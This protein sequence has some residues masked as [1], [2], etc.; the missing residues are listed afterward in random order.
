MFYELG[1][2]YSR[3]ATCYLLNFLCCG[4]SYCFLQLPT[5]FYCF[6]LFPTVPTVSYCPSS[7]QQAPHPIGQSVSQSDSGSTAGSAPCPGEACSQL[8]LPLPTMRPSLILLLGLLSGP[9]S[10]QSPSDLPT[11]LPTAAP[12]VNYYSSYSYSSYGYAYSAPPS[13]NKTCENYGVTWHPKSLPFASFPTKITNGYFCEILQRSQVMQYRNGTAI[14]PFL[15][16]IPNKRNSSKSVAVT[17]KFNDFNGADPISGNVNL[18]V[19][20]SLT[21]KD[22]FTHWD[23]TT[24]CRDFDLNSTVACPT[25][26]VTYIG[27]SQ[28]ALWLPDFQLSNDAVPFD[29]GFPAKQNAVVNYNGLTT[30]ALTG[31]IT[32]GCNYVLTDFPFDTQYCEADFTSRT[33]YD[34]VLK[35]VLDDSARKFKTN[36]ADPS[37]A[38]LTAPGLIWMDSFTNPGTPSVQVYR[39]FIGFLRVGGFGYHCQCRAEARHSHG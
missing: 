27:F 38:I 25:Y 4:A 18:G 26:D 24:D 10:G 28:D 31:Q 33:W 19:D 23:V 36:P 5:A 17:I 14:T 21:W 11:G 37:Q 20:I 7:S 8:S 15:E 1:D 32:Y 13:K 3:P 16:M 30:Y 22:D 35:F 12:S 29:Q 6:L 34:D 39:R 9:V 2:G